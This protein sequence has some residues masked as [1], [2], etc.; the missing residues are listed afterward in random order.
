MLDAVERKRGRKQ[1]R[2]RRQGRGGDVFNIDRGKKDGA[3]VQP[4]THTK[5]QA[6]QHGCLP[7]LLGD[8]G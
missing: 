7:S 2:E 1:K 6:S 5:I 4:E 3:G 8:G